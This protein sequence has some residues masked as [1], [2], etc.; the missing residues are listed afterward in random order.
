M[1]EARRG[2]QYIIQHDLLLRRRVALC[3]A[4]TCSAVLVHR[5]SRR[6]KDRDAAGIATA[7]GDGNSPGG[8]THHHE[9]VASRTPVWTKE[10]IDTF[11][12]VLKNYGR[13]YT[14]LMEALPHRWGPT[15]VHVTRICEGVCAADRFKSAP[16]AAVNFQQTLL[17]LSC[18]QMLFFVCQAPY[19]SSL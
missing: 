18:Y 5:S 11:L 14:K 13:D 16:P 4:A 19:A 2:G 1:A 9:S 8:N 10:E 3:V 6:D 12:D 15:S 7:A 17:R